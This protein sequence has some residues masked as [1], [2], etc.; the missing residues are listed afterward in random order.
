MA[1]VQFLYDCV[2]PWSYIGLVLLRRYER[3]WQLQ[4]DYRPVYLGGV[5]VA[6]GNKPPI[7]VI[8]KGIHMAHE[9]SIIPGYVGLQ[10]QMPNEFPINTIHVARLLRVIKDRKPQALLPATDRF[11]ECIFD[12]KGRE[13]EVTKA[14]NL[15]RLLSG[16]DGLDEE[17]LKPLMEEAASAENKLRLKDEATEAV[18]ENGA[19]GC[20]W[21]TIERDD[22]EKRNFFGSDR[23][24]IIAHWLGKEYRGPFPEGRPDARL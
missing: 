11:F 9:L 1:K 21:F 22:G 4:V 23:F 15:P 7:T 19:F 24:E 8:N 17:A 2:S 13:M 18:E 14:Q 5:M 12:G 10:L 3:L 16:I 20:P 6:A